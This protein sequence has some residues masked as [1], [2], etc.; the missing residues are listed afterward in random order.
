[1][2]ERKSSSISINPEQTAAVLRVIALMRRRCDEPVSLT[3]MASEACLSR[4]HFVRVFERH[5]GISPIKFHS[6]LRFAEARD[7][8]ISTK[9]SVTDICY[10][11][12][13][14]SLSTF[15]NQFT[16]LMGVSP[17]QLRHVQKASV[18]PKKD[19]TNG[20]SVSMSSIKGNILAPSDVSVGV[21]F[22][23]LF[24]DPFP[25][26]VPTRC[27]IL[28]GSCNFFIHHIPRGTYYCLCCAPRSSDGML[29]GKSNTKIVIE[30]QQEIPIGELALRKHSP[31][32]APVLFNP[33]YWQSEVK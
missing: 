27:A 33:L 11:L 18:L 7:R 9:T 22:V 10:D 23:G 26:N 1:M 5:T 21:I 17:G 28:N 25:S 14:R 8:I 15:V 16:H 6:L 4:F 31:N 32:D 29:V 3:E 12:G 2:M 13:F 20:N 30:N 19:D 24:K